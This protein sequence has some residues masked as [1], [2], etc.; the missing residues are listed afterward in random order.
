MSC[1]FNYKINASFFLKI[2]L[3]GCIFEVAEENEEIDSNNGKRVNFEE[4]GANKTIT[5]I[6]PKKRFFRDKIC[7]RRVEKDE[8]EF[9]IKTM[10]RRGDH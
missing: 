10:C 4:P 5:D 6:P 3:F 7:S 8:K 9:L 2:L 1:Y